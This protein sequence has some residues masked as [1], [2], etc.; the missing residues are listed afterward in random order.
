[1]KKIFIII[2]L[3]GLMC[4][5]S[6]A[7]KETYNWFFGN[8]S[9]LTF[10]GTEETVT[11]TAWGNVKG[12]PILIPPAQCL[13]V[14]IYEGC[15][16]ISDKK[17]NFL[18]ASDGIT[19]YNKNMQVMPNGTG[20][21]G[22]MSAT[23]SGIMSPKPE[24]PNKY[25]IITVPA[26]Y[27]IAGPGNIDN[28][29]GIRYSEIDL[30]ADG[31][32]G[33][34]V[35]STKNSR[36]SLANPIQAD[37]SNPATYLETDI[38]E[39][40]TIVGHYNG[41][42][43]WMISKIK[44]HYFVW[45]IT[46]DGFST[47]TAYYDGSNSGVQGVIKLSPD[48]RKVAHISHQKGMIVY[49]DF[50][51]E[52]GKITNTGHK[53]LQPTATALRLYSL[54]FSTDSK[55]LYIA[56]ANPPAAVPAENG[57][58][59]IDVEEL[60]DPAIVITPTR[61]LPY[62]TNI[63]LGADGRIYGIHRDSRHLWVILDPEEGGNRIHQIIDFFD[64]NHMPQLGLPTFITSFFTSSGLET[65]PT[66][67]CARQQAELSIQVS[68]GTGPNQIDKIV[69]D[70]GD[71]SP[72]ITTNDWASNTHKVTHTYKKSG[73]YTITITPYYGPTNSTPNSPIEDKIAREQIEVGTCSIPVNH[74]I[75]NMGY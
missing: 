75:T 30:T 14:S 2:G 49:A 18:F 48:G 29:D 25:Y 42:D 32:L 70:L 28:G 51:P 8:R 40:V 22:H 59:V 34:I 39:N 20:L 12:L 4:T 69:W 19:A 9:G 67:I 47:P 21:L 7:Q 27:H 43:Y 26:L 23:H 63:Q 13:P 15:F 74:N 33:A 72:T 41:I 71:G 52:T 55:Y 54:E 11:N 37:L 16:S 5:S 56:P 45:K 1:M 38:G 44:N 65:T 10:L 73:V 46:K 17:G 36:L 24:D 58:F 68:R 64:A 53:Q 31:G 50:D 6:Y 66:D 61:L 62:M 57:L 35:A 60:Y 3:L